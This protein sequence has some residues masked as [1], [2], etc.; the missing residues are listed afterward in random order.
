MSK[1]L[2]PLAV[3]AA[4]AV[5]VIPGVGQVL[6][7]GII[8][9]VTTAGIAAGLGIV[10]DV[11][12]LGP[13]SPE[14]SPANRD[15]FFASVDPA[16]PRKS[17]FG[18]TA[19]ATD[20][21][22]QEWENNNEYFNQI[23]CVA[24]HK[25][26]S[27]EQI[28]LD[29]K[30]AWTSAGGAQGEFAGYLT[31]DTRLEGGPSNTITIGSGSKWGSARRMTGLAYLRMRFKTTGNSKKK[32][33]PFAQSIPSRMTII[34]NGM[35]V[36]DP[37]Y[38]DTVSG[39]TGPLRADD[40]STWKFTHNGNDIG[41]NPANQLLSHMLGW[42]IFNPANGTGKLAVGR[43]VPKERFN[44]ERWVAAANAC[45][46][47]VTLAAGGTEKR[48]RG[49]GV[50]S[51]A[52]GPSRVIE[53]F[54]TTANAKL[55]DSGGSFSFDVFYNDLANI[56][57]DFNDSDI[58]DGYRWRQHQEIDKRYNE[59]RGRFS[60][61][62]TVSLYQLVDYPRYQATPVDGIERVLPYDLP[63][64]QSGSQAQRLAKQQFARLK[65]QGRFEAEFGARAWGV[66]VGDV[67]TLTF[68]T[69]GWSSK[70]FRV[71]ENTIG[72][73]GVCRV[74]LQEEH[75]DIYLWDA[76]E[77]PVVQPV[78]YVP[79]D[80]SNS[81]FLQLLTA[82][83]IDYSDGTSI[84][85]LKPATPNA[86]ETSGSNAGGVIGGGAL[87]YEDVVDWDGPYFTGRPTWAI[88]GR[89]G[90]GLDVD[91]YNQKGVRISPA[92]GSLSAIELIKVGMIGKS[93]AHDPE[94]SKGVLPPN[95]YTYNN[96][97]NGSVTRSLVDDETAPNGSGKILRISYDGVAQPSPGYG[98]F[99][100]LLN[101]AT[102]SSPGFY[103][104]GTKVAFYTKAKIPVGRSINAA[105][106]STGNGSS[107]VWLTNR[108]GTGDWEDYIYVRT[109][110]KDGAFS[111]TGHNYI[112]TGPN[113]AFDWDVAVH[114]QFEVLS[115]MYPALNRL[116]DSSGNN[117]V[118][119]DLVTGQGNA[120][121]V[122]GA[123][124]GL[125]ANSLS[126]LNSGEGSK[127]SGIAAGATV[128]AAWGGNLT[129]RPTWA[130]DG[131]PGLGLSPIGEL[132]L[133]VPQNKGDHL[134]VA[135]V[136]GAGT[137]LFANTLAELNA[138]EGA[139]FAGIE[140]NATND[141]GVDTRSTDFAP[142]HYR[143]SYLRRLRNEFKEASAIGLT[144]ISGPYVQ[145][146]TYAGWQDTSG[147]TVWQRA[148]DETGATWIRRSTGPNGSETWAAW[149]REFSGN[150][151]PRFGLDM[152]EAQGG[153]LATNANY[154]TADGNASGVI[155]A[156]S[157]LF[158]NNLSELNA[159][160][161]TK[162]SGIAS[163]ATNDR[164]VDTR[165]T[166]ELPN[167]YRTNFPYQTKREFKQL[168][169]IGSP[170]GASGVYGFLH[171]ETP[172][173]HHSG[174]PVTQRIIDSLGKTYIRYSTG[175]SPNETWTAWKQEYSENRK[176]YFGADLL[177][178]QG[179]P[180]ATV[181]AFRTADGNA[182]GVTGAGTG[183]FA[184]NLSQLNASEG[185]KLS[186]IEAS[187]DQTLSIE[188][189]SSYEFIHN[190]DGSAK[191]GQYTKRFA[192]KL[193]RAGV[194]VTS[195]AVFTYSTKQGKPLYSTNNPGGQGTLDITGLDVPANIIK[196]NATY[197]GKSAPSHEFSLTRRRLG[198]PM[199]VI[200][201]S[202][203]SQGATIDSGLFHEDA[204]AS[205]ATAATAGVVASLGGKVG[206][207]VG[208]ST[209][210]LR[211]DTSYMRTVNT[212]GTTKVTMRIRRR[213]GAGSWTTVATVSDTIGAITED[214]GATQK[215]GSK[216][217][218][219]SV[220]LSAGENEFEVSIYTDNGTEIAVESAFSV[221]HQ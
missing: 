36:Y 3:V 213:L 79:Y 71:L 102:K 86:D 105:S 92:L 41:R 177:E 55:R 216:V 156:G 121:G 54:E 123:G 202:Y 62:S 19:M 46:E 70:L 151:K 49:D 13:K 130:I 129:G 83:E 101:K 26:D 27:I 103:A 118:D 208:G 167:Y 5:N 178:S 98:G 120:A 109:I 209:V 91:G 80:R 192:F 182:G 131:R 31:V 50:I 217:Y 87:L 33:S 81:I 161:G 117:Q 85:A 29:D 6:S 158:A 22:Y 152:L 196:I 162:L 2:K 220:A 124:T 75:P 108:D 134:N 136:T 194:D 128:G 90:L 68:T 114:D 148:T 183:L 78:S 212:N 4:I 9:A 30:L 107:V 110:G 164:S 138:S 122:T 170:P 172:W 8:T 58:L 145:A 188:G 65:Y 189:P 153:A 64:V 43:G 42:K 47:S 51:E 63:F 61:P 139:K 205:T 14:V 180:V 175:A 112:D 198:A 157:G 187:A 82:G 147:G 69:L 21:R 133:D 20:I 104:P 126:E 93:L 125:F 207:G 99:A 56:E 137:G 165:A 181:A 201:G 15:R 76:D 195:S 88:D 44:L 72:P 206:V 218:T 169:S 37:R 74:V 184:N 211:L 190:H 221:V 127:L 11:L 52:D 113:T 150:L 25:V 193:Y 40:Q 141:A 214:S 186:G 38:D 140:T 174:G 24:S 143:T 210:N 73:T 28:W 57:I 197:S 100:M 179:G 34:G 84:E 115:P 154:R 142:Q 18:R 16:T 203:E 176:P 95:I 59:I 191:P 135:G 166:N 219:G 200:I 23:I 94:F 119:A 66:R 163:S 12:G 96:L 45:D 53:W 160:E 77:R 39:G 168:A 60:D 32:E 35:P 204:F 146:I 17:V 97:G 185:T 215:S 111:T 106:N 149:E 7:A 10:S 144:P 171:T 173:N 116:V 199:G 132:L 48:Y 159:G 67:V 155:G 89:P 1:L